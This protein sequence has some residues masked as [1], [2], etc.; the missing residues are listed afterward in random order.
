MYKPFVALL[1]MLLGSHAPAA[2]QT[3]APQLVLAQERAAPTM[4][5]LPTVST[6]FP[7]GSTLVSQDTGKSPAQFNHLFVGAY[8]RDPSLGQLLPT[9]RVKNLVFTQVNLPLVQLWGGRLQLEAFQCT[10]HIQNVQLGPLGYGGMQGFRSARQSYSGGPISVHLSGLS[11]SYHF[12]GDA[13]PARP[14]GVLRRLTRIVGN[15]LN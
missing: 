4:A 12:G 15:V 1:G 11:L 10:L 7:A 2:A 9:E 8:E 13:R 3:P 6:A 14:T 5:M